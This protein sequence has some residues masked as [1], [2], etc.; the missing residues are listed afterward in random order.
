VDIIR[1]SMTLEIVEWLFTILTTIERLACRAAEFTDQAGMVGKAMR[2]LDGLFP[3][4]RPY[5]AHLLQ[6]VG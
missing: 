1:R 3:M 4:E 6:R 2:T 5:M